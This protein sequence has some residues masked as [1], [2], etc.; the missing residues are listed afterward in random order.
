[1]ASLEHERWTVFK[2]SAVC[3]KG[4]RCAA[5]SRGKKL[6]GSL[7]RSLTVR[8]NHALHALFLQGRHGI[9][10]HLPRHVDALRVKREKTKTEVFSGRGAT[11]SDVPYYSHQPCASGACSEDELH[12]TR[13]NRLSDAGTAAVRLSSIAAQVQT[14]VL[15]TTT[16]NTSR[17]ILRS[18][19]IVSC[20]TARW[21]VAAPTSL[22]I[23]VQP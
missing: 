19:L 4:R 22:G 17:P 7:V 12:R 10:H 11:S 5:D 18:G 23:H 13:E 20:I 8:S 14:Q 3:S 21:A 1:M 15:P 2:E 16:R 6:A 9:G